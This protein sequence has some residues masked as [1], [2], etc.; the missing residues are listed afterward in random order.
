MGWHGVNRGG[1]IQEGRGYVYGSEG[2][3][4]GG[5]TRVEVVCIRVRTNFCI[6]INVAKSSVKVVRSSFAS[7]VF[8]KK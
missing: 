2:L 3:I 4:E 7:Y 1:G 5:D 8:F 6:S